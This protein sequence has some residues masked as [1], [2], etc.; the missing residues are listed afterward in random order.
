MNDSQN[1]AGIDLGSATVSVQDV[2][3]YNFCKTS[4][5]SY[6]RRELR[7]YFKNGNIYVNGVR[8]RKGH[9]DE[10]LR[11]SIG[12]MVWIKIIEDEHCIEHPTEQHRVEQLLEGDGY[13][14]FNKPCGCS[15][16]QGKEYEVSIRRQMWGG[17]YS[18]TS[19]VLY[20]LE[21]SISG[22]CIATQSHEHFMRLRKALTTTNEVPSEL[23]LTYQAVVCGLVGQAGETVSLT[24]NYPDCPS[25]K[26][27]VLQVCRSRSANY[28]SLV[29]VTPIFT[30]HAMGLS[31][32]DAY[33]LFHDEAAPGFD[34]SDRLT[35]PFLRTLENPI[36]NADNKLLNHPTRM[37]KSLRCALMYAGH[38]IVGD[39]DLVKKSKGLYAALTGVTVTGSLVNSQSSSKEVNNSSTAT[40][41]KAGQEVCISI[42]TPARFTKLMEREE[43]MWYTA[44]ERDQATLAEH[45]CR[46]SAESGSSFANVDEIVASV[47]GGDECSDSDDEAPTKS[48]SVAIDTATD[49]PVEYQTREA[50]FCGRRFHVSPSVMIPRRSS[51][52][53]VQEAVRLATNGENNNN[54]DYVRAVR[55]L[56]L[57]TG[58]GCLL[59]S[60]VLELQ[61]A[62]PDSVVTGVGLD[63]STDALRIA[64]CNIVNLQLDTQVSLVE[65]SFESMQEV[66]SQIQ[67]CSVDDSQPRRQS[68]DII[69]CNPPYSSVKDKGRL[70]AAS[71]N[72]EPAVAL[73]APRHTRVETEGGTEDGTMGAYYMIARSLGAMHQHD[74]SLRQV[75]PSGTSVTNS[76]ERSSFISLGAHLILEMGHGQESDVKRIITSGALGW[77]YVHSVKDHKGL[78]RCVVFKYEGV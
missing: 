16:T 9:D 55:V 70:S 12:D 66:L 23:I 54:N 10:T 34:K 46:V 29:N 32:L 6:S 2:K 49:M 25:L 77:V 75:P 5:G 31:K 24:T 33:E 7:E 57:G 30:A 64:R 65:G 59:L 19:T 58:S 15:V 74:N 50:L 68:F 20:R 37:L 21:K 71:R 62:L 18:A 36:T 73:F 56:D 4:I 48:A 8:I 52:A 72:H 78:V 22:L 17:R 14:V 41:T 61:H 39:R 27:E 42:P 1:T 43:R 47:A 35:E 51:E 63:I 11:L 67:H 40:I 26:V 44:H 38:G 3:L 76:E 28:L 45:R 69:L 13:C 60:T 53:L